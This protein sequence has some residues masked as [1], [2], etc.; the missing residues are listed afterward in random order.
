[1]LSS[2]PSRLPKTDQEWQF[3]LKSLSNLDIRSGA[4]GFNEGTGY[5]LGFAEGV[6]V[7]F[8]GTGGGSNFRYDGTN[9]YL[10]K[11]ALIV[12]GNEASSLAYGIQTG[13][14][15]DGDTITFDPAFSGVPA[16]IFGDGGITYSSTLG[17]VNTQRILQALN[18]T[19]S[20]FTMKAKLADLGAPTARSFNFSG[21]YAASDTATVG[22]Y[23][24]K[25]TGL[26]RQAAIA[27]NASAFLD[28][29]T[30][31]ATGKNTPYDNPMGLSFYEHA[32]KDVKILANALDAWNQGEDGFDIL[33]KAITEATIANSQSGR[34]VRNAAQTVTGESHKLNQER[35][36]R[37]WEDLTKHEG[38]SEMPFQNNKF[39]KPFNREWHKAVSPDDLNSVASRLNDYILSRAKGDRNK[40]MELIE[41]LSRG[42][43]QRIAPD[44]KKDYDE[45]ARFLLNRHPFFKQAGEA[46]KQAM[47]QALAQK[48]LAEN[49]KKDQLEQRKSRIYISEEE[50]RKNPVKELMVPR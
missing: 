43:G 2:L 6:P 46:D 28:W 9:L 17:A 33:A 32:Q 26:A 8:V 44:L 30:K 10:D 34:L 31:I 11:G 16:I 50:K 4:T 19:A 47:E 5:F 36:L 35:D 27:G 29:G 3:F 25:A 49:F 22:D 23:A 45:Y 48:Y 15:A 42:G 13:T 12:D 37:V 24:S 1:M 20:G 14:A 40:A 7:F 39:L 41:G 38:A 18:L 21:V